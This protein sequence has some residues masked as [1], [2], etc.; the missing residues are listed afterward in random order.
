MS[1]TASKFYVLYATGEAHEYDFEPRPT[2]GAKLISKAEY[3]KARPAYCHAELLKLVKPGTAVYTIL[4]H[5]S[6]S[7]MQ[8]RISLAVVHDGQI[9]VI[10]ALVADLTG[11]KAHRDGGIVANGCGMDMGYHLVHSLGYHLW[12]AGTP[13]PHGTRNGQPDTS[14]GYAL[15]HEWL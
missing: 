15:R 4:R 6:A 2:A 11:N 7:G 3:A 10:D 9:R 12:P 8:R 13:E 1:R 14:G 5:C